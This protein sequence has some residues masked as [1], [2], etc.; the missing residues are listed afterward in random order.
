M[1][2][3]IHGRV[4]ALLLIGGILTVSCVD[5]QPLMRVTVEAPPGEG[6]ENCSPEEIT[7]RL[8]EFFDAV[9]GDDS[10]PVYDLFSGALQWYSAPGGSDADD[11]Q[12]HTAIYDINELPDYFAYRQVLHEQLKLQ[13][14]SINGGWGGWNPQQRL[15]HFAFKANRRADD[16]NDGEAKVVTGKGAIECRKQR[17]VVISIGNA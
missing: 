14:I 8:V 13:W 17:F 11:E 10:V 12:E 3:S 1:L 2:F 16:F 4:L 15:I 7:V 5:R 6:P 9:S